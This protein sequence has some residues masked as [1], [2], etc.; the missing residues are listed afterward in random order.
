MDTR[1]VR[2]SRRRGRRVASCMLLLAGWMVFSGIAL[3]QE[4]AKPAK[5]DTAVA[6]RVQL[7]FRDKCVECHGPQLK[8]PRAFGYILDLGR[9][10]ANPK[11][12]VPFKPDKSGLWR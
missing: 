2:R 7:I 1:S 12:V 9:V 8:K 5:N 3:G 11:F 10:A 6:D 4:K